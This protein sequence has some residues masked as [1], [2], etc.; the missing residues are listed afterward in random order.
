M[1]PRSD[2]IVGRESELG[3]IDR[4][5]DAIS[6]GPSCLLIEGE[7]GIGKTTLWQAG[8]DG[9][10]ERGYRMLATRCGQSETKLSLTGLGDLVNP[11]LD[12]AL[13]ELPTPLAAAIETA[14]LRIG[15]GGSTPDRR[16]IS[17]AALEVLRNV[18]A[19]SPI[20]W[21]STISNG[22]I[23]LPRGCWRS[24]R[25]GCEASNWGSSRRC[26]PGSPHPARR[27]LK[28]RCQEPGCAVWSWTPC[29]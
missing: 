27:N 15:S 2:E 5:L 22:S 8:V 13:P 23:G 26:G 21:V 17:L 29:R 10:A 24:A 28:R 25:A 9:G 11:L 20:D 7:A 4:F 18:A 1:A 16:A 14:F 6:D 19:S 3:Q 12:E